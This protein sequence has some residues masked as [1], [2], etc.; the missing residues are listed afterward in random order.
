M[1]KETE[2]EGTQVFLF[3]GEHYLS[4]SELQFQF[5]VYKFVAQEWSKTCDTKKE[6]VLGKALDQTQLFI[7]ELEIRAEEIRIGFVDVI[8]EL[9][10]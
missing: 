3:N 4:E 6:I 1:P 10:H 9:Y 8:D 7:E 5:A 2:E